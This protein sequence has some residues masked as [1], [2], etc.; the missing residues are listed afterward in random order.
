VSTNSWGADYVTQTLAEFD[1]AQAMLTLATQNGAAAREIMGGPNGAEIAASL[2]NSPT[3]TYNPLYSSNGTFEGFFNSTPAVQYWGGTPIDFNEPNLAGAHPVTLSSNVIGSFFNAA[4]DA[5]RGTGQPAE[6]SA[7][8]AMN[9]IKAT[10]PASTA[11]LAAPVQS[12]LLVTD[13]GGKNMPWAITIGQ[14]SMANFLQQI[15]SNPKDDGVLM[16]SAKSMF[17]TYYGLMAANKLP[18]DFTGMDPAREMSQLMAQIQ[19]QSNNVGIQGAEATDA[20]HAEY[21]TLLSFAESQVTKIPV[22][23]A[24]LGDAQTAAGLLGINLPSFSTNNAAT[25]YASD[26]QNFASQQLQINIPMAQGLI[27]NGLVTTR[28]VDQW[29]DIVSIILMC[30]DF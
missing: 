2:M 14:T 20:Q 24:P 30:Y 12:A 18:S 23:G 29:Y 3:T 27:H 6:D 1:P 13:Q 22:V 10:P 7:N 19:T 21:N 28:S 8:A 26:Q 25:A 17:G 11:Q 4:T 16:A 5:P 15:A 9:I